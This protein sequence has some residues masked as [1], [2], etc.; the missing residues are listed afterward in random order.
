M[1]DYKNFAYRATNVGLNLRNASDTLEFG[2]WQQLDNVR[3]TQE[4]LLT[5][6]EGRVEFIATS[7]GE[8]HSLRRLTPTTVLVGAGTTLSRNSTP[9]SFTW[10]GDTMC[11]VPFKPDVVSEVWAYVTDGTYMRKVNAGGGVYKWGITAPDTAATG[12]DGGAGDLDS[13][14]PGAVTYDWRY[15]YYSSLTGAESNPSP[16]NPTGLALSGGKRALVSVVASSDPQVDTIRLYRRGG[17]NTSIWRLTTTS[18][19]TTGT[20]TDNNADSVIALSTALRTDNYVPFTS[21][22][23]D[24]VTVYEAALPHIWGPFSGRYILGCGDP[25]RPG[26]LYWTNAGRPDSADVANN[27]QVTSPSEPLMNGCVFMG[28]TFVFSRDNLYALDFG[29]PTAVP[30]FTPRKTACGRGLIGAHALCV[31]PMIYF[32]GQ[33]GVY[34]TDGQGPAD[35]LTEET[36]RPIFEGLTIGEYLPVDFSQASKIR[37]SFAGQKLHFFYSTTDEDNVHLEYHTLYKRWKRVVESG[38]P[39]MTLAYWDENQAEER[40]LLGATDGKVYEE[41]GTTDPQGAIEVVATTGYLDFAMPQTMKEFGN[42]IMDADPQGGTITITPLTNGVGTTPLTPLVI[43]GNGRQ[44]FPISLSDIYC[45]SLALKFEWSGPATIYQLELLWRLDE[46]EITH[47]EFPETTHGISGW[48][49]VRDL[50]VALRSSSDVTLTVENDGNA[51]TYTLPSTSGERR[52][53]HVWLYPRKGKVWRYKLDAT[54]SGKFRLY[55][56]D[57]EVRVKPWNTALGYQLVSPWE[58]TEGGS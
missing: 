38:S 24:G 30:T 45:Y 27:L 49:Q 48:Q 15:T 53:L 25:N 14:V 34:Q 29:G 44:K 6:R 33:D 36:L 55:G 1:T 16:T 46:E 12:A 32:V 37:L 21:V 57:C 28:Q 22:D 47:W 51:E 40:L 3:S 5:T 18:T 31:G 54:G 2:Q 41:A 52:K 35:S 13:S 17:T 43:T 11:I 58:A 4:A 9:Y 56:E 20:I 7:G 8:V 39:Q 42:I 23:S 10:A 50:Y 19:N 26:Y